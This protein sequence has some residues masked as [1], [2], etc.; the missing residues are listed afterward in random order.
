MARL[1]VRPSVQ[2]STVEE[3]FTRYQHLKT[4][5]ALFE[6][7]WQ[8]IVRYL[9]PGADDVLDLR[10]VGQSRTEDIYDAD[11]LLAPLTL[12]GNLMGAVTNPSLDW[13]RFKFR[14]ETLNN[15]QRANQ[16]LS[17]ANTSQLA[18]YNASNFYQQVHAFYMSLGGFGTA[19]MF[20]GTRWGSGGQYLTFRTLPIGTYCIAEDPD[21]R[22]DTLYRELHYTPKQAL[23][24]FD[25]QVSGKLRAMAENPRQA[26]EPQKFVHC[27][28]PRQER[29][30]GRE[31]NQNMPY[32]DIVF[33]HES[34][35]V[36]DETGH[37]EFPFLVSRWS[38]MSKAP[39]GFG[40]GHMA[41]PDVRM[42]NTMRRLHI[43]QLALWIQPPLKA[44]QESV[45]GNI[46]LEPLAVNVVRQMDAIQPFDLTGRPD[47]VQID[48]QQLRDSIKNMFF[49][50]ALQALPPPTA[51]NM[52]A[53]E[54]SQRIE[55]MQRLMGP[56]FYSLLTDFL[57]PLADRVFGLRLRAGNIPP[58]PL[59][60]LQYIARAG[61]QIDVEYEGPLA[62]AQR[63]SDVQSIQQTLGFAGQ[64]TQI[65]QNLE[66][67]DNFDLDLAARHA[68]EVQ[69]FPRLAVRDV[70]D[71]QRM[72]AARQMAQQQAAQQENL[73][74]NL[75]AA[76]KAAPAL[77]VA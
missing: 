32:A 52:T 48:Q 58:P 63:N 74:Q 60:V 72:R 44:L 56:V 26:D 22:V 16:W 1:M 46:S 38:K 33:E 40:P 23:Q 25:G 2:D 59:E 42:L 29:T 54:V 7:D 66:V 8:D 13:A 34:K 51:S 57:D 68:A 47:L 71:V 55:M 50:H 41:L 24:R 4:Q 3:H 73:R 61:G 53:Y 17:S 15:L 28:Y 18:A 43:Q 9:L 75:M 20:A 10:E 6:F 12:A 64:I 19:A 36:N 14:D 30:Y 69:G 77:A 27:V 37:E 35:F 21:G 62:R 65:V 70:V 5:R 11:P 76:G 31:D 67:L 49:V 39:W 45:V